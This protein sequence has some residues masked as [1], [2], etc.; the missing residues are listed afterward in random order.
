MNKYKNLCPFKWYV[1]ENFPFIEADFD[2]ITNWQLFC[3]LGEEINKVI[4]KTNLTG[5]QVEALTNAFTELENYLKNLDLQD[6][7]NNKIDEM[8]ES[9]ELG[10]IIN[11]NLLKEVQKINS[12]SDIY[13]ISPTDKTIDFGDCIVIHGS[14]NVII[15][16]GLETTARTILDF[17][18]NNNITK[19][20]Y[21]VI[22]HYHQDH[23]GGL[24][25]EGLDVLLSNNGLDFSNC[26]VLLPHRRNKL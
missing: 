16:L 4:N 17:L 14:K 13:F 25:G 22:S 1:L 15:D 21:I 26:T 6:E 2:A 23:I 9:G 19:I 20:D 12:K 11:E 7:V 8:V 5:Q 10:D 3:K 18:L 24:N